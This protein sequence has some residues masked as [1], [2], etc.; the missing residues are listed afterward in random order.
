MGQTH[1]LFLV[2]HRAGRIRLLDLGLSAWSTHYKAL[3]NSRIDCSKLLHLRW[4]L[5]GIQSQHEKQ[6]R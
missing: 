2:D 6:P 5:R 4:T 3:K 1:V